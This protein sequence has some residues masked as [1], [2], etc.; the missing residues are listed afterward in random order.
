[1]ICESR[2]SSPK[3]DR[4]LC[5]AVVNEASTTVTSGHIWSSNSSFETSSPPRRRRARRSSSGLVSMAT[6]R[7]STS[8]IQFASSKTQPAKSQ[9]RRQREAT[10][11]GLR[12]GML[13]APFR[14]PSERHHDRGQQFTASCRS[15][16]GGLRA[17]NLLVSPVR[18]FRGIHHGQ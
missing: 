16:T 10:L 7:P 15:L 12:S 2:C 9:R 6:P 5:T 13:H 4:N 17:S 14:K 8:K 11:L 3:A 18:E 1:M